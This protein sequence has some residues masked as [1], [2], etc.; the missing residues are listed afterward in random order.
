MGKVLALRRAPA[1]EAEAPSGFD[2]PNVLRLPPLPL[3]PAYP[4][5]R[6]SVEEGEQRVRD[7]IR[8]FISGPVRAHREAVEAK[9][10]PPPLVPWAIRAEAGLGK[11]K[12]ALDVIAEFARAGVRFVYAV[13][14]HKLGAELVERFR[15]L[16]VIARV[17]HGPKRLD[18]DAADPDITMCRDLEAREDA[19]RAGANVYEAAC[20][21]GKA[22]CAHYD[23]CGFMRQRNARPNVW[24]VTTTMLFGAKPEFIDMPHA[25][26]VDERFDDKA[27]D[28]KTRTVTLDE[29]RRT[30]FTLAPH[31]GDCGLDRTDD[32]IA[33]RVILN[34]ALRDRRHD[35]DRV[36]R[37]V[38]LRHG[39]TAERAGEAYRL[40]WRR[41][42]IP[43]LRPGMAPEARKAEVA[44]VEVTNRSVRRQTRL[45]REIEHLLTGQAE[46]SGRMRV[47]CAPLP[48]APEGGEVWHVE[49]RRHRPLAEAW[50]V[51]ILILDATLPAP[52]LLEAA[53][54]HP[55]RI[56][57]DVSVTW[58]PSAVLRQVIGAPVSR[59]RLGLIGKA[60]A[61]HKRSVRDLHRFIRWRLAGLPPGEKV[62]VIGPEKL[63]DLL[64]EIGL[65]PDIETAHHGAIAGIDCWNDVAAAVVI[66]P[67]TPD[68]RTL[69]AHAGA[70]TGQAP[71]PIPDPDQAGRAPWYEKVTAGIRLASGE[72][73]ATTALRHPD[74]I[75]EALRQQAVEANAVQ[76]IARVRPLR[77]TSDRPV[78]IDFIGDVPL[79][80]SVDTVT[81]W[82]EARVGAWV[83]M[84]EAGVV[85]ASPADVERASPELAQTRKVA[86]GLT[87]GVEAASAIGRA[88]T[89]RLAGRAMAAH[90]WTMPRGPA[91]REELRA[92]LEAR[93][94]PVEAVEFDNERLAAGGT[95]R[96]RIIAALQAAGAAM[97]A[98]DLASAT[99]L[100][101]ASLRVL[102]GRLTE[103]DAIRKAAR[104]SYTLG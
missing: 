49:L 104:G 81:S 69:E 9:L 90:C 55:V 19:H 8:A 86:R 103:A 63:I 4:D 79:P 12:I 34:C 15:Q 30:D 35:D 46:V 71:T 32:L 36:T 27:V 57:A 45:W 60:D 56:E 97:T 84:T 91:N 3:T 61:T 24:I 47:R 94:G 87:E 89:Y 59:K 14:T 78:T 39:V 43:D 37:T 83:E 2:A 100:P 67:F 53:M 10:P 16:G 11:T 17:Y 101:I 40:E 73:V 93:L 76:A 21:K 6:V 50:K 77:R 96:E 41:K 5:R 102:L 25:L 42:I 82:P 75:V 80:L 88:A 18:P 26:I 74:P 58:S 62:V 54:K 92:W 22:R 65:P 33:A 44:R 85:L 98:T 38:L 1:A 72:A 29:I 23:V 68:V 70:L 13:P 51:P 48:G 64:R 7:A 95:A 66:A 52:G 20:H 28:D 99:G 31:D